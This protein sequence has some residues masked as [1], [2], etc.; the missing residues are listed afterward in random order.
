MD[1]TPLRM[2]QFIPGYKIIKQF[3]DSTTDF[4]LK[5]NVRYPLQERILFNWFQVIQK[6]YLT[7]K[8]SQLKFPFVKSL[9]NRNGLSIFPNPLKLI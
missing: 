2:I 8:I 5:S 6:T 9:I 7:I 3:L 4:N 1:F